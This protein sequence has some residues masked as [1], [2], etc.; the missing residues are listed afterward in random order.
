MSKFDDYGLEEKIRHIL[1]QQ[2]YPVYLPEHQVS[3]PFLS[4]YQIAIKLAQM[5]PE[6][7]EELGYPVGGAGKGNTLA[8]YIA[9]ILAGKIYSNKITDIEIAFFNTDDVQGVSFVHNGAPIQASSMS[10]QYDLSLFRLI[11]VDQ[12][13]NGITEGD[14]AEEVAQFRKD[15]EYEAWL[16]EGY[17]QMSADTEYEAEAMEWI[18]ALI[19]DVDSDEEDVLLNVPK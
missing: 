18:E 1:A 15:N 10:N 6:T 8:Q 17:R 16:Y 12:S 9:R 11:S 4:A 14:I 19:G 5:F 2:Y 7:V 3:R 13:P